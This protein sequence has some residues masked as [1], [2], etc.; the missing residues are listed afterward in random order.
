MLRVGRVTEKAAVPSRVFDT[1]MV[2]DV[3]RRKR[4]VSHF[5][6]L[7]QQCALCNVWWYK[8][9]ISCMFQHVK[10]NTIFCNVVHF[11]KYRIH[12]IFHYKIDIH[13]PGLVVHAW[14]PRTQESEVRV[15]SGVWG[16]T[17]L[18]SESNARMNCMVRSCL[19]R[20]E[21]MDR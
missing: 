16:Q 13:L 2:G 11:M 6:W 12:L 19:K 18:H 1:K 4:P 9:E 14:N 21:R 5:L 17:G 20:D 7:E 8:W 10:T 15:L 3:L